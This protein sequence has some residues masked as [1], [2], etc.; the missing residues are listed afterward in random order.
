VRS[1][2]VWLDDR[3]DKAAVHDLAFAQFVTQLGHLNDAMS[4]GAKEEVIRRSKATLAAIEHGNFDNDLATFVPSTNE[5]FQAFYAKQL[6]HLRQ[7]IAKDK[8]SAEDFHTLR[9]IVRGIYFT[10]HFSNAVKDQGKAFSEAADFVDR[11]GSEMNDV[12]S[13]QAL[14]DLRGKVDYDKLV[15]EFPPKIKAHIQEFLDAN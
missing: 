4:A 13:A 3:H 2:L 14:D 9:K 5:S 7:G 11:I 6:E 1:L 8:I 15:F 10:M 12:H